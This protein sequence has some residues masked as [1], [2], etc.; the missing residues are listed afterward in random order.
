MCV[1]AGTILFLLGS[2]EP[3]VNYAEFRGLDEGKKCFMKMTPFHQVLMEFPL[4]EAN[5]WSDVTFQGGN[6]CGSS[7]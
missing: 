3:H 5:M 6:T 2:R 7:G 1:C 4:L